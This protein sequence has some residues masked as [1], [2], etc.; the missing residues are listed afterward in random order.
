MM[1]KKPA[2]KN[3]QNNSEVQCEHRLRYSKDYILSIIPYLF[4]I[5]RERQF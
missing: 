1:E 2:T 5:G 4:T 3:Q